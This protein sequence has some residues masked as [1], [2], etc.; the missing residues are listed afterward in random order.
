MKEVIKLRNDRRGG[1]RSKT[2]VSYNDV[3]RVVQFLLNYTDNHAIALPGRIPGFKQTDIKIFP[4]SETKA[5]IWRK[6][7]KASEE[8]GVLL[9]N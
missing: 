3:E 8:Q 1:R 5:S 4:S 7:E 2:A 9:C 6:Y